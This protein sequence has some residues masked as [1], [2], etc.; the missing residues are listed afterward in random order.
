MSAEL[1]ILRWGACALK[2]IE[3]GD[4]SG[5]LFSGSRSEPDFYAASFP[6]RASVQGWLR[7]TVCPCQGNSQRKRSE[8]HT[9]ELQS[10]DHLV[11]R[12]LLEKNKKSD[13]AERAQ[14]Y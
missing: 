13:R 6:L 5:V 9:S 1:R 3:G 4:F 12:L 10:P 14:I 8:E 7:G 2:E 11:C